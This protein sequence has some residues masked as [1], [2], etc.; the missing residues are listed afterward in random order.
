MCSRR[1]GIGGEADI[2]LADRVHEHTVKAISTSDV[3]VILF[4]AKAGLSPL[5][6][7]TVDLVSKSELPRI[8]VA[9][10]GE[11][12]AGEAAEEADA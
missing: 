5:D 3:L 4:D 6:R 9:N 10:K 11:G 7:E 12:R 8:Y 2:V 1:T